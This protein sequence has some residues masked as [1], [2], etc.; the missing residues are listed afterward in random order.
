MS[1]SFYQAYIY[2]RH[3]DVQ[4]NLHM[5][6]LTFISALNEPLPPATLV[7]LKKQIFLKKEIIWRGESF[8]SLYEWLIL[9][10]VSKSKFPHANQLKSNFN[11]KTENVMGEY[12]VSTNILYFVSTTQFTCW[13]KSSSDSQ[14]IPKKLGWKH[15]MANNKMKKVKCNSKCYCDDLIKSSIQENNEW[16]LHSFL[17]TVQNMFKC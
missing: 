16:N 8:S 12:D 14:H 17:T 15:F 4:Y 6:I 9:T 7:N 1:K 11:P 3:H 5:I 2:I 10:E 13:K